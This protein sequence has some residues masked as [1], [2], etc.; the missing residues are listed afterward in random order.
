[1]KKLALVFAATAML[2][3]TACNGSGQTDAP[4]EPVELE[5]LIEEDVEGE[6]ERS[7]AFLDQAM[8]MQEPGALTYFAAGVAP[9]CP[10]L[11]VHDRD[12]R[13]LDLTPGQLDY[14][15]IVVFCMSDPNSLAALQHVNELVHT[16]R[17]FGVRA[18][19]IVGRTRGAERAPEF[20]ESAGVRMP[21][22]WDDTRW[23]ALRRM[24]GRADS[25]TPTAVPAIFLVDRRGRMRFYRPGFRYTIQV[26]DL[27][28]HQEG[29]LVESAPRGRRVVDYLERILREG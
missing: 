19:A 4:R 22:Y 29:Q 28:R 3:L 24:A 26:P 5:P 23:S 12:G 25:S 8:P 17:R 16:Y 15:T 11:R 13:R 1:M 7:L 18:I 10:T 6:E 9:E 27:D 20:L 21:V 2:A 14:V